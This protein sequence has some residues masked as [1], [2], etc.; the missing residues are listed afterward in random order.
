MTT[1]KLKRIT[2]ILTI[3]LIA[4][5]ILIVFKHYQRYN[6][7]YNDTKTYEDASKGHKK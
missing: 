6:Q 5:A 3:L 4:I 2:I 7:E 1:K